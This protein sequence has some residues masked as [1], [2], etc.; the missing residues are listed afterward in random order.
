VDVF[1]TLKPTSLLSESIKYAKIGF[2]ELSSVHLFPFL[3]SSFAH[4]SHLMNS[5]LDDVT[6]TDWKI[7]IGKPI[8]VI[9]FQLT[10]GGI[11]LNQT[12][13]R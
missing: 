9:F 4:L 8:K 6:K 11:F 7:L 1:V 12:H 10:Y 2:I 3:I 13:T 5:L